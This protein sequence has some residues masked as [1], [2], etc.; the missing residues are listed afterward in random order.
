M[1]AITETAAEAIKGV[2]STQELPESAG[3]RI[4]A[5]PASEPEGARGLSRRN[6]RRG[7]RGHRGGGRPGLPRASRGGGPRR[8]GPRRRGRSAGPGQLRGRRAGLKH[9]RRSGAHR[10]PR[11]AQAEARARSSKTRTGARP[12]ARG[13]CPQGLGRMSGR[14]AVGVPPPS[15]PHNRPRRSSPMLRR[16]RSPPR[17][18]PRTGPAT[19][20]PRAPLLPGAGPAPRRW[21][22]PRVSSFPVCPPILVSSRSRSGRLHW[23]HRGRFEVA[24]PRVG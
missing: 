3:V 23:P 1:L 8:Q 18:A 9:G 20:L 12:A 4:V 15:P 5:R 10:G 7:R 2:V 14:C 24:P 6:P 16:P 11:P 22:M 19:G 17:P 21:R 13:P